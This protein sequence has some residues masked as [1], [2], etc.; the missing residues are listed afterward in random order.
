MDHADRVDGAQ[1]LGEAPAEGQ[2]GLGAEG[3]VLADP[4]LEARA[5]HV[6]GDDVGLVGLEV[7]VEDGGDALGAHPGEGVDLAGQ[8]GAGVVVVGDVRAQ[9]LDRHGAPALVE[10]KVDD[11]HPALPQLLEHPVGADRVEVGHAHASALVRGGVVPE[12]LCRHG[13]Q[14]RRLAMGGVG[15]CPVCRLCGVVVACDDYWVM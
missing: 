5:G 10:G 6:A 15:A 3:T 7:G 9:H 14:S 1:R 8:A 13:I 2:Q 4:L 12:E 11:A